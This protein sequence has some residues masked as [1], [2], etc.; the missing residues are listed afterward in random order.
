MRWQGLLLGLVYAAGAALL[1]LLVILPVFFVINLIYDNGNG[2]TPL[3]FAVIAGWSAL[4]WLLRR[5]RVRL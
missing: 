4:A 5:R 2:I 3:I 1:A